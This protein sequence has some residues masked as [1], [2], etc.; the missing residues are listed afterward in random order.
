M[1]S[2]YSFNIKKRCKVTKL[3]EG[4]QGP[5]FVFHDLYLR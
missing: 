2:Y 3:K 1:F 5:F 4:K